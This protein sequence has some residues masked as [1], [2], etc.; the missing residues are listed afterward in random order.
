MKNKKWLA[1]FATTFGGAILLQNGCLSA[2]WDGFW[3]TG[4]PTDN[5]W[6][7]IGVDILNEELFG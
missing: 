6:V 4:W 2:F 1:M 3:T 7:N 5:R